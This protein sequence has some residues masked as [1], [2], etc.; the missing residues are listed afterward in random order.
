MKRPLL[1]AA[2]LVSVSTFASAQPAITAVVNAASYAPALS[3]GAFAAIFGTNLAAS[4]VPASA[5]P[6]P[7]TLGGVS[8]KFGGV[9]GF[10]HYVS[11]SQ[12]NALIP[13]DL[14]VP[15]D[16][17]VAVT[18]TTAEGTSAEY[19][20]RL[21]PSAPAFFTRDASGRGPAHAFNADWTPVAAAKAG[22]IVIL[23][24]AGLG[25][26]DP[27]GAT[28]WGG[29]SAEPLNRV[30]LTSFDLYLGDRL[31][32]KENIQFAGLAPQLPGVYQL[33][34]VVPSG[35]V[36][37]RLWMKSGSVSSRKTEVAMQAGGNV[38]N[39]TAAIE[40][41]WPPTNPGQP[42]FSI[43]AMGLVTYS[44]LLIAATWS[45][46]FD[47]QPGAQP[48]TIMALGEA[49]YSTIIVDPAAGTYTAESTEPTMMSSVG[50]FSGTEVEVID[51]M[52][53]GSP[54]AG[55]IVPAS[56][57]DPGARTALNLLPQPNSPVEGG[58]TGGLKSA[59][60]L[61]GT[62]IAL[63]GRFG[64]FLQL[65]FSAVAKRTA[66]FQVFVDGVL[67]ASSQADY[68]LAHQ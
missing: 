62:H 20:I 50:N 13:L 22:D 25:Q 42:P 28:E 11:P 9:P 34:V 47:L 53:F 58:S 41:L 35:A 61:S 46:S 43:P 4:A 64:G 21:T 37:N 59:G 40:G 48:F 31:V 67:A 19:R 60:N 6:L 24:A 23:Y 54:M 29:A 10:L 44:P 18:A 49:G 66:V 36:T 33:N 68:N 30:S 5:L 3:P 65:P 8:V 57:F 45:V 2:V 32:P 17:M 56:R 52:M 12:I 7:S 63:E 14:T 27:A 15:S 1:L 51:F 38:A 16:G 55:N 26:T 39:V